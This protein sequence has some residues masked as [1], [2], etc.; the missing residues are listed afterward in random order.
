MNSLEPIADHFPCI[1]D[2]LEEQ[3]KLLEGDG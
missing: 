1:A 3:A 2:E